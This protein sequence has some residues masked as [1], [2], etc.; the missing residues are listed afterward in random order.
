MQ[1]FEGLEWVKLY[2]PELIPS[3]L[4]EEVR[5]RTYS[6]EEFYKFQKLQVDNPANL[7]F[8]AIDKEKVI[9]AYLWAQLNALDS[10]MFVNT[11]SIAKEYWNK[12]EGVDF[13]IEFLERLKEKVKPRRV[14]WCTTNKRFFKKKGFR[15]SKICLMEEDTEVKDGSE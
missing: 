6:I 14:F 4:I 2:A 12:G 11:V 9:K 10:T 5:G 8:V 1:M 3:E 13:T 7:L 15:E